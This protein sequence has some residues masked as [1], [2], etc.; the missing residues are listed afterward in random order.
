[1]VMADERAA[2]DSLLSR[3][4]GLINLGWRTLGGRRGSAETTDDEDTHLMTD[5]A[6]ADSRC[7]KVID[8]K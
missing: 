4:R 6:A 3:S 2:M 8:M 1:M 7:L 5:S